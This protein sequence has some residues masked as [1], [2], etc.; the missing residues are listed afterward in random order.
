MP[1]IFVIIIA[2]LFENLFNIIG[3]RTQPIA[4]PRDNIA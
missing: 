1:K 3:D 4:A 2:S